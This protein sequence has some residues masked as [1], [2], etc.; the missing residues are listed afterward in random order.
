[1]NSLKD[2]RPLDIRRDMDAIG[3]LLDVA[4]K[5]EMATEG[6]DIRTEVRMIKRLVPVVSVMRHVSETFRHIFDGYVIEDQEQIIAM[7][8][9]SRE[10]P[11][12]KRWVIGNV[13]T[14]PDY[15]R[16]GLAR[17]LIN[18]A[19]EYIRE[20]G[21]ETCILQVRSVNTPAYDLY[22]SLGFVHYDSIASLKLEKLPGVKIVPSDGYDVHQMKITEWESRY[23]LALRETP[24]EV[25]A[26]MPL[27][28]DE[29]NIAPMERMLYPLIRSVQKRDDHR[30]AFERDGR[31]AGYTSLIARRVEKVAHRLTMR[32]LPE[33]Q[34]T[35]NEPMLTLALSNLK[36]YPENNTLTS[37]RSSNKERIEVLERYGFVVFDEM[38]HL[39]LKLQ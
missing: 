4:F 3:E 17:K 29:F 18:R 2:L 8:N 20:N 35:L 39:G 10:G 24:D 13:A 6:T 16:R 36:A 22:R 23:V 38:H 26:F 31:L 7:V 1:M 32:C 27:N 14:H 34:A 37:I 28:K 12:S 21:A 9:V 25:Q 5:D 11:R 33:S 19:I 30:W 15:R